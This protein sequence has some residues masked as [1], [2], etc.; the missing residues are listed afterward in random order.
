MRAPIDRCPHRR[1]PR[2]TDAHDRDHP[3]RIPLAR[4]RLGR[5]CAGDRTG[6]RPGLGSG[7]LG[8]GY[9]HG[10]AS[11]RC[12]RDERTEG[13]AQERR[14]R[15]RRSRERRSRE[16]RAAGGAAGHPSEQPPVTGTAA[17]GPTRPRLDIVD[18]GR[19]DVGPL[20]TSLRAD[21][22]DQRLPTG[23][24]RVYRVPGSESLLMRGNGALFAVFEES[25]Y[26]RSGAVLPPG[27]VFHI[28]MPDLRPTEYGLG[29]PAGD[30]QMK[31]TAAIGRPGA[32][33]SGRLDLRVRPAQAGSSDVATSFSSRPP[34]R[35]IFAPITLESAL[36][37]APRANASRAE[38]VPATATLP[39]AA[40]P[41]GEGL[42]AA[43]ARE[44]EPVPASTDPYAS[45]RLGP[46]RIARAE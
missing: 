14:S 25:V 42:G 44:V 30:A 37:I 2:K 45:L 29:H 31:S 34:S 6:E 1:N 11:R 38:G 23:F 41:A 13:R 28:G 43:T 32:I 35:A 27:T 39:D 16:R 18:A 46:A 36:G 21:P 12:S 17:A 4:R 24:D 3:F 10:P 40:I 19:E 7:D 20:A 33:G 5:S 15:E 8:G 9:D 22:V 26:R